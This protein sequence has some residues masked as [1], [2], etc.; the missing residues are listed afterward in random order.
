MFLELF[1]GDST[2]C[3][4]MQIMHLVTPVHYESI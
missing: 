1:E 2:C 4:N 3:N